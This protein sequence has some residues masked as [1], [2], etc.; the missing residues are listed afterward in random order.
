MSWTSVAGKDDYGIM[1]LADRRF[2]KKKGQLPKWIASALLD[3]DINMSVDQA[4]ATAKK[5]LKQMSVPFP[6]KL[7]DGVSTWGPEDL[8][9]HLA[10]QRVAIRPEDGRTNGHNDNG[11]GDGYGDGSGLIA[12]AEM[13][14]FGGNG[15]GDQDMMEIEVA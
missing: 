9:K 13:D 1:V 4:V 7:Q 8:R 3:S 10:K 2:G 6:A 15:L 12:E 14:E 11:T 5:F